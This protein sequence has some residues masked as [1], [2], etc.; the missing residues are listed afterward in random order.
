MNTFDAS[1]AVR[2]VV[3]RQD[4]EQREWSE[5]VAAAR[6]MLAVLPATT[7]TYVQRRLSRLQAALDKV[8][9]APPLDEKGVFVDELA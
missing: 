9:P 6:D 1:G 4:A 3:A 2:R 5:V 7:D 8:S